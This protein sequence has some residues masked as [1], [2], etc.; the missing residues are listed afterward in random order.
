MKF[1]TSDLHLGHKNVLKF[2][3][4][5][6]KDLNEMHEAIIENWNSVITE[7]DDVYIL[8]DF[9]WHK[10][11][12]LETIKQLKG[13]KHL[14]LGNHDR[15]DSEIK[16]EFLSIKSYDIV[17]DGDFKVVLSHFPLAHWVGERYGG[18]HLYGHVHTGEDFEL[19]KEY[20]AKIL[21]LG[22]L[23]RSYNVGCM[24]HNYTPKTLEQIMEEN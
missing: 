5:P 19:L 4:R 7:N 14:I 2:D 24:L 1:Y 18:V 20:K 8:G 21:K 3:N 17:K 11:I 12:G 16:K 9:A 13:G 10:E 23:Y 22:R 6:F 15:I